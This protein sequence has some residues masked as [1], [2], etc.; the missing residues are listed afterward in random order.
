M[1]LLSPAGNLEKLKYA[2][3]YGADAAYIGIRSF[4]LRSRADNFSSEEW[5]E[6]AEIKGSRKL[7]GAMNIFFHNPDLKEL[8]KEIDYIARYPFDAFIVSD[9]GAYA[10]LRRYF[11]DRRYHLSTQANCVN[12]EAAKMY[13]DLGFSRIILGREAPLD[14]IAEIKAAAPDVELE[15]FVHGAMCLAYSGRCYLSSYLAGRSANQGDCTHSCRWN[16]RVLEEKLRP[17]EYFPVLEGDGFTTLLSSKDLCMYDHL[18]ELKDAG[19]DSIKIEGR[20]KSLYYTALV[21]RSYRKAL[22][23]LEKAGRSGASGQDRG[24][25]DAHR[26]E[27]YKIS[28]REFST[29]F[30]FGPRDADETTSTSYHRQYLFLGTV[31]KE[32][33]GGR[34]E[35]DVKNHISREKP[36]EF[37]GP[38]ILYEEDREFRLFD[39]EGREVDRADHGKAC[40]I[41]PSVKVQP[42]YILRSKI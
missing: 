17:G 14:E 25:L 8:E 12:R 34:F 20:M 36:I 41:L 30:F 24:L 10:L 31:G 18:S 4:S 26:E 38:D 2:Y 32:Y 33:G 42:G 28:R 7:Y 5:R 40:S 16:Y 11:P 35:I 3:L 9:L 37:I 27:L 19:I 23:E 1:E 39:G 6:I 15:A 13:R 21:T 22:E 29:G